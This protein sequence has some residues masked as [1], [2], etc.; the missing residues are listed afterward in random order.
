MNASQNLILYGEKDITENVTYCTYNPVTRKYDVTFKNGKT[1]NYNFQSIEWIRNP[2]TIN[3]QW[4]S[5]SHRDRELFNIQEI[6][7]FSGSGRI[8]WS[9]KFTDGTVKSYKKRELEI[10][11]SCHRD[12]NTRSSLE[13]LRRIAAVNELR[14]ED[15]AVLLHKQYEKL[16][17]IDEDSAMATY[18]SPGR[19]KV[20]GYKEPPLIFPFGSNASQFRAV[21]SAMT[22]QF[23][24]IEG[25]PGTGKTQTILNIIS[26]IL[27]QGKSV[28]VVSNNNSAISNVAEK[29]SSPQ[30]H[31]GFL[32]APLGNTEN[33]EAFINNQSNAYPEF[34]G[35]KADEERQ[36]QFNRGIRQVS[37]D[38]QEVFKRQERLAK[39]R[40]ELEALET[41]MKHF[42][43]YCEETGIQERKNTRRAHG[44]DKL[45]GIW[46]ECHAFSE[47]GKKISFWFKLKNI[48]IIGV[49]EWMLYKRKLP[50][51]VTYFQQL[52]YE[53]RDA[54]LR[55]EIAMLQ[56][57][58]KKDQD[59]ISHLTRMSMD[60]LRAKLYE[61]YGQK[62]ERKRFALE[63]LWKRPNKVME[64]YPV[65]LSTT[66]SS[67]SSLGKDAMFDYLI[68][69]EASQVDVATGALALSCARNAVIVGDLRQLPNVIKED[70]RRKTEEIFRSYELPEGY[71]FAGNSFLKSVCKI[72]PEVPRTLLK[73]HYRCHPKI[74][75]FCNQKFYNNELIVMTQDHGEEDALS[76]Y[77]TVMGNHKREH[78]NQRQ[79][80]VLLKEALPELSKEGAKD[81]GIIAP[82]NEQVQAIRRDLMAMENIDVAT[83]H[84]FQGREKDTIILTPVDDVVTEFSDDP[85]LL[86]VAIS[87]AK[88]RLCLVAS[89]NEQPKDSNIGDLISYIEYNNFQVIESE[90]Y[91]VFD[92]LYS[93]YTE[94]RMAYLRNHAGV[95]EYDSENLMYAT[96][97]EILEKYRH[98]SFGVISHQPLNMLIRDPRHL[99]DEETRYIM[100]HATHV[101]FLVYSR[102]TKKPAFAVEVDG[103][104]FH[105]EGTRQRE[106]DVMKDRIFKLYGIP[107]LRFSTTGSGEREILEDTLKTFS[108]ETVSAHG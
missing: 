89:G 62:T 83:V 100:N 12:Q 84:K 17:F 27:I 31:L 28:L 54:E 45:M 67:R 102:I 14:T 33:K 66:F 26:N 34:R 21:K 22:S 42:K 20:R 98:L 39:A 103:F 50:L 43:R 95:S 81:I 51:V 88:K 23:S 41:E 15:G 16:D 74:I 52:Y 24:V 2:K 79:I 92:Y 11:I 44:S 55:S 3:H 91:S 25:P 37:H 35:W 106:R 94:K 63:D 59:K 64:E 101:D 57:G 49:G 75:G 6:Y 48:R 38:L 30:Y 97:R 105:R 40:Q 71:S 58:L 93:Q 19:Y 61:K 7:E 76:V 107:L 36:R 73:E 70:M 78:F 80:D 47:E 8:F 60:F 86:N 53:A 68:M 56:E 72:I 13:Y 108:N 90:V 99:N 96:L 104:H 1:Y 9:V 87:R 5:I 77:R 82:Y 29:L 85:Y 65:I 4:M 32:V 46:Q 18:M 69:D 10:R